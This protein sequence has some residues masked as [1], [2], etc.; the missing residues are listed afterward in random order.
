MTT[1]TEMRL[2]APR[3]DYL[4]RPMPV[5]VLEDDG[6]G[7]AWVKLS[8]DWVKIATIK[9]L[10][11]FGGGG[12]SSQPSLRMYFRAITEDDR[13]LALFQDLLDGSWYQQITLETGTLLQPTPIYRA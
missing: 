2:N 10:W 6:E 13:R 12:S 9:N 3:T 1:V 7:Q 11:D 5:E 4:S 8:G